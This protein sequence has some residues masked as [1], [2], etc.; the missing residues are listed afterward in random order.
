VGAARSTAPSGGATVVPDAR[1]LGANGPERTTACAGRA[2]TGCRASRRARPS[3]TPP[4]G[5]PRRHGLRRHGPNRAGAGDDHAGE[6]DD[7][8][9]AVRP[10]PSARPTPSPTTSPTRPVTTHSRDG[11]ARAAGARRGAGA[12][13]RAGPACWSGLVSGPS[14]RLPQARQ[15]RGERPTPRRLDAAVTSPAPGW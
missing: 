1:R 14:G 2:G 10:T 12:P 11:P 15:R 7:R 9:Q 8:A 6:R 13:R 5:P 3:R 4:R